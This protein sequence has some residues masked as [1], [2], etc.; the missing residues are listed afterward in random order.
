MTTENPT[1]ELYLK[2]Y[3]KGCADVFV[4]LN[5]AGLISDDLAK[6]LA[7]LWTTALVEAADASDI[8]LTARMDALSAFDEL[9]LRHKP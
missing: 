2:G 8:D 7:D 9:L 3:A 5:T 6:R 4:G 1:L